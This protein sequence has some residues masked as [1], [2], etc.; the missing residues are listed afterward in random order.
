MFA[1]LD[2]VNLAQLTKAGGRRLHAVAM[3][4]RRAKSRTRRTA[5]TAQP[6]PV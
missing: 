6:V 5:S 1:Y 3:Q 2:S 4:D